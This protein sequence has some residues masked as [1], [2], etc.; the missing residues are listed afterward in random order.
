MSN[1]HSLR[2]IKEAKATLPHL[3]QILLVVNLSIKGLS[4]F[5]C[6]MPVAKILFTLEEQRR[7]LELYKV[8]YSDILKNKGRSL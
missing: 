7:M 4:H 5:K 8:K 2:A 3:E 1:I 6:Y